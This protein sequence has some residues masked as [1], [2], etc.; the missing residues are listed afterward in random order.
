MNLARAWA[1]LEAGAE[2]YC[3]HRNRWWQTKHGPMLDSGAFVAGLELG[4]GAGKI[5]VREDEVRLRRLVRT[6]EEHS[7]RAL[8]D[9][10]ELVEVGDQRVHRQC[11][12]A[13]AAQRACCGACACLHLV[14]VQLESLRTELG[15][16]LRA[17]A[18]RG[19]R[20]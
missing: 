10:L 17:G 14:V 20:H 3:L 8:A 9:E 7:V 19:I 18:G 1:E 4:P 6:T 2:L 5:H 13:L 11:Q 15:R 12:D 16:E